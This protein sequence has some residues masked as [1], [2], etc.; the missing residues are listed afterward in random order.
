[1]GISI[2]R[3]GISLS[4]GRGGY[5]WVPE[6]DLW[7]DFTTAEAAP[8]ASPR[9][10]EPGPGDTVIGDAN[11]YQSIAN[12]AVRFYSAG[13][14]VGTHDSYMVDGPHTR[15]AGLACVVTAK[16]D[17]IAGRCI[18]GWHTAAATDTGKHN[19]FAFSGASQTRRVSGVEDTK[20]SLYPALTQ[21]T[22]A[23]YAII[24][25]ATGALY[26]VQDDSV[27][28]LMW[29]G[30]TDTTASLYAK[31][32]DVG[33]GAID[34]SLSTFRVLPLP[35][36]FNSD[37][38]LATN[39]IAGAVSAGATFVHEANCIIEITATTLTTEGGHIPVALRIS[40]SQNYW[41]VQAT[42]AH[43][44]QLLEIADGVLTVRGTVAGGT[45][46]AGH[47][48]VTIADGTTIRVYS[49]NVLRITYASATNS[50][51]ATNGEIDSLATSVY[52]DLIVW[53]RTLTGQ[54]K[55]LLD[56]A[57]DA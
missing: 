36:P 51:T 17:V 46:E 24:L 1:M 42:S 16:V 43:G 33:T 35:A 30:N 34:F 22:Y 10:C 50:A 5:T 2:G 27:W 3:G 19:L 56:A 55:T 31:A 23:D 28:R 21:S 12:G 44:I 9:T 40:D 7:D 45:L 11:E 57:I 6:F 47:R 20:E 53:P 26:A 13:A 39:R 32:Y 48:I 54:A 52:S 14:S 25:R 41:G 4:G 18:I 49:N 37:Y 8:L 29:V 15:A 38:G